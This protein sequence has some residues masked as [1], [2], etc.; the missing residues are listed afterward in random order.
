MHGRLVG[1]NTAI[2][3]PG[4]GNVGI[5]FAIPI[6]MADQ[7]VQ[8]LRDFGEV[9]RGQLGISIQ[10]LTHDLATAFGI[11]T[12]KGAVITEV[13]RG[14]AAQ[15][16]GLQYSDIITA[17]NNK[18]VNSATDLRNRI[19]LLRIG[20]R[21]KI[22]FLRQGRTRHLYAVIAD[23][24]GIEGS[25]VSWYL[26]GAVLKDSSDGIRVNEITQGSNADQVG[27]VPGDIIIGFNRREVKTIKQLN[28][29]FKLNTV[30][31]IEIQR[32]GDILSIR[33][34]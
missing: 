14:S 15:K 26:D 25:Q 24:Q 21:I 7:I 31:S 23:T 30:R 32:D 20:E 4:G 5:G 6:N 19:G 8:H 10:D 3:A 9:K 29:R 12:N 34:N 33:L 22:T 11:T 13:I 27:L 18:P 28:R 2:I 1:I 16:A 17:I